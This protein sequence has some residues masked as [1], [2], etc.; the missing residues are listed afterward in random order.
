NMHEEEHGP[1]AQEK[2]ESRQT[3][4]DLGQGGHA[5]SSLVCT[6]RRRRRPDRYANDSMALPLTP[7]GG[8]VGNIARPGGGES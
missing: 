5:V 3:N 7:I 6:S 4:Q 8:I 1:I 2:S